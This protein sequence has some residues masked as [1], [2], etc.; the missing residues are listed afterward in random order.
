MDCVL[1]WREG[2]ESWN[3]SCFWI[4]L[5]VEMFLLLREKSYQVKQYFLLPL[6]P[7]DISTKYFTR[8]NIHLYLMQP[9]YVVDIPQKRKNIWLYGIVGKADI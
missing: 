3:M 4:W 9:M 5:L 8:F 2:G 1:E 7:L 6:W